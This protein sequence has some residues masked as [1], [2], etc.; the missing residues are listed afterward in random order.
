LHEVNAIVLLDEKDARNLAE[1]LGLEVM[2][3]V[4]LLIWAKKMGYVESLREELDRLIDS[5]FW[6]GRDV[7][8]RALNIANEF[9]T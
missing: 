1:K 4:G 2:G 3:T 7:Y 8:R 5:G 6:L 9:K